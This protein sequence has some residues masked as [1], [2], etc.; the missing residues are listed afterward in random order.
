MELVLHCPHCDSERMGFNFAGV[1]PHRRG[2]QRQ[3]WAT[4]T[5]L[6]TLSSYV[7][8]AGRALSSNSR[9]RTHGL[10]KTCW[11]PSTPRIAAIRFRQYIRNQSESRPPITFPTASLKDYREAA[12]GLRRQSFTSAGMMFRK[13]LEQAT[14]ELAPASDRSALRKQRLNDRIDTLAGQHLLTPAMRDWAHM[15]RLEGNEAA[16][17]EEQ[18]TPRE[19]HANERVH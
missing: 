11:S 3:C 14:L 16:H 6:G 18:F 8:T 13:V 19:G 9:I 7:V 5:R 1:W 17:E 2:F 15:I 4:L 12:D 10:R